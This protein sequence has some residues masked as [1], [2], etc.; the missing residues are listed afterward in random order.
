MIDTDKYKDM[1]GNEIDVEELF[2]EIRRLRRHLE[3]V[4][5]E[6]ATHLGDYEDEMYDWIR[7]MHKLYG[8]D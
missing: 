4:V 5:D 8:S 6:L 1:N 2:A 3:D 7:K